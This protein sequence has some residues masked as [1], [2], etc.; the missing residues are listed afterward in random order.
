VISSWLNC[1]YLPPEHFQQATSPC[2][3]GQGRTLAGLQLRSMHGTI[4]VPRPSGPADI[5]RRCS[6]YRF[7]EF[8][9][10]RL[11]PRR[12]RRSAL[13]RR[14]V[15]LED[16]ASASLMVGGT[17]PEEVDLH[18]VQFLGAIACKRFDVCVIKTAVVF[19]S[20]HRTQFW[21]L[22]EAARSRPQFSLERNGVLAEGVVEKSHLARR[23]RAER[24]A[25]LGQLH[26]PRL[27]YAT[28]QGV[29]PV[30]R[31]IKLAHAPVMRVEDDPRH[32]INAV[33]RE[34]QRRAARSGIAAQPGNHEM[35]HGVENLE[36]QIVDRIN[37][38]PGFLGRIGARLD[39]VEVDAVGPEIGAAQ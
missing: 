30:F 28:R 7:S 16:E 31:S 12:T 1:R 4:G 25:G 24:L 38:P 20:Q 14:R 34:R 18:A 10:R 8:R 11:N 5:L 17:G 33:S 29:R 35:G 2:P 19:L 6:G 26:R 15:A 39:R 36:N 27:S 37:V 21:V 32:R 23:P 9:L 22:R 13:R 3:T